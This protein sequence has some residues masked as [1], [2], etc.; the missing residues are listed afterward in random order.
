MAI[1][2]EEKT[3]ML[4]CLTALAAIGAVIGGVVWFSQQDFT[5][6]APPEDSRSGTAVTRVDPV[7]EKRVVKDAVKVG[8]ESLKVNTEDKQEE[9][10]R[11]AGV[12]AAVQNLGPLS[13]A[14]PPREMPEIAAVSD[15]VLASQPLCYKGRIARRAPSLFTR[16]GF[17]ITYGADDY[18]GG[19]PLPRLEIFF[20]VVDGGM[21]ASYLSMTHRAFPEFPDHEVP[22]AYGEDSLSEVIAKWIATVATE[23][24]PDAAPGAADTSLVD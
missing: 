7:R 4:G 12:T 24:C 10:A 3:G 6:D 20:D 23:T 15:R 16:S 2:P 19:D 13:D 5:S 1:D 18:N 14:P 11:A 8:P 17:A 22:V 21:A 9:D